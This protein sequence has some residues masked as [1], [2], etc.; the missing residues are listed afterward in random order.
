MHKL[1][2]LPCLFFCL[3]FALAVPTD[4]PLPAYDSALQEEKLIIEETTINVSPAAQKEIVYQIADNFYARKV[5]GE[6]IQLYQYQGAPVLLVFWASYDRYS[7]KSLRIL[8]DF[9]NKY[10][11]KGLQVVAIAL[12]TAENIRQFSAENQNLTFTLA[13]GQ[14]YLARDYGVWGLPTFYVLDKDLGI[15]K[16]L[17]GYVNKKT[18][19]K[20]IK[21]IL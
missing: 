6:S 4:D 11:K 19:E 9:Q 15:R 2:Y 20:E 8:Q 18:L 7:V 21:N 10:S 17:S 16:I 13:I 14:K 12:D 5:N 1:I 3:N